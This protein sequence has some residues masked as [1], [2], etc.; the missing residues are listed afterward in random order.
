MWSTDTGEVLEASDACPNALCDAQ[1]VSNVVWLFDG[2]PM[3]ASPEEEAA[4]RDVTVQLL[5]E[6]TEE[7]RAGKY[8]GFAMVF[9][10]PNLMDDAIHTIGSVWTQHAV[11]NPSFTGGLVRLTHN[12][13]VLMDQQESMTYYED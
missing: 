12:L 2:Q 8:S 9:G 5:E 1:P 3:K 10:V 11:D 4:D 13:N 7:F 6:I